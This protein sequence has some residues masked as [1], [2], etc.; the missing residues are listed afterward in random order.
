MILKKIVDESEK[1]AKDYEELEKEAENTSL[2]FEDLLYFN[3]LGGQIAAYSNMEHW[4]KQ[5]IENDKEKRINDINKEAKT[6]Y[7][8]DMINGQLVV[9]KE[10]SVIV[11]LIFELRL[12]EKGYSYIKNYLNKLS[13]KNHLGKEFSCGAICRL[14]NNPTYAGLT[15]NNDSKKW[16]YDTAL[17]ESIIAKE[18][19]DK[20]QIINQQNSKKQ[21]RRKQVTKQ[22]TIFDN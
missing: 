16:S 8:F 9:N 13:V 10:E 14:L 20:V 12:A 17:H 2:R 7:G 15:N 11:K 3:E 1:L 18:L 4:I 19:W 5:E 22:L 21:N 6:L